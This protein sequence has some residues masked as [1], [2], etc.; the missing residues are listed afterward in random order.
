MPKHCNQGMVKGNPVAVMET[1][2][3]EIEAEYLGGKSQAVNKIPSEPSLCS[4]L[5]EKSVGRL[6]KKRYG[7]DMWILDERG[8]SC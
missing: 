1:S 6:T 8:P 3:G 7:D 2:M 5:A 4:F